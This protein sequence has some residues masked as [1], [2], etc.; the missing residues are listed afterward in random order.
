MRATHFRFVEIVHQAT[1]RR[2]LLRLE[3]VNRVF[4]QQDFLAEFL[5]A[6]GTSQRQIL[7]LDGDATQSDQDEQNQR[8]AKPIEHHS[9]TAATC[10]RSLTSQIYETQF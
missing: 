4:F 6:D 2:E 9:V 8:T 10:T 5:M 7:L 3:T 1:R